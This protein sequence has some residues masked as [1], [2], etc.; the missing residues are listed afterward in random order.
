MDY[1]LELHC[2]EFFAM[3][4]AF[5]DVIRRFLAANRMYEL[6]NSGAHE[7]RLEPAP[8]RWALEQRRF[9]EFRHPDS[10]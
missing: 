4:S 8:I 10:K 6:L 5:H 3:F 9:G 7:L 2:K 1:G